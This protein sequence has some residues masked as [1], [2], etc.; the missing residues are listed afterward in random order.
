[1][2][3]FDGELHVEANFESVARVGLQSGTHLAFVRSHKAV[4]S[5]ASHIPMFDFFCF[6]AFILKPS[7]FRGRSSG[8][9]RT[10]KC[11]DA[12]M[13]VMCAYVAGTYRDESLYIA[14]G[15]VVTKGIHISEGVCTVHVYTD[16]LNEIEYRI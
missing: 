13:V 9:S 14:K 16:R 7:G 1:M 8:R 10:S 3:D 5:H 2:P 12:H 6:L 4:E 15:V 11:E